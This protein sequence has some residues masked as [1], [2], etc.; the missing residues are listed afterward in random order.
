MSTPD[1]QN[2]F[3]LGSWILI[4]G[5]F[6][7]GLWPV[8]VLLLI[9]K[10]I[11]STQKKSS[12]RTRHPYDVQKERE[13]AA[14]K[15]RQT[16]DGA[17]DRI[18]DATEQ[19]VNRAAEELRRQSAKSAAQTKT[20]SSAGTKTKK[21]ASKHR[22]DRIPTGTALIVWG[23]ILAGIFALGTMGA[24]L[25]FL[26]SFW[27]GYFFADELIGVLACAMFLAGG[28]VMLGIGLGKKRR[29]KRW[30]KYL[31]LIGTRA[32]VSVTALS[33]ASGIGRRRVLDDLQDMLDAGVLSA[34]YLD[35]ERDLLVLSADGIPDE[36]PAPG[37]QSESKQD[38]RAVLAEIRAVNDAIPDPVMSE[39]IDRIKEI[40]G[41]ILDYQRQ[42]PDKSGQ[43]RSFLNYY[44]PTTLKILNSYAQLDAQG[45][46]GENISA[47]KQRIEGMMDK[48]VEGF[49]SQLDRLFAD[50]AMDIS[51]DV[52]VL[53]QMLEKD[54]L[55][56]GQGMTMGS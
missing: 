31:S 28:L 50:S 46:E 11:K 37:P 7:V 18:W 27:Y 15:A 41:K 56:G 16:A 25:T 12:G 10:L 21:T 35:M 14:E 40:T 53:E 2:K 44:L 42:N 38:D 6:C 33:K 13:Q 22:R 19:A 20:K 29:G 26:E 30:L 55:S 9:C 51:S 17:A 54:G 1:R 52:A 4:I 23:A 48:V 39:K 5:L 47:A 45:V 32:A 24:A 36:Q 43:L 8:S 3:D 49:E 34:G